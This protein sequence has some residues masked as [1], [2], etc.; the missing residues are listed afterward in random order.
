MTLGRAKQSI[1]TSPTCIEFAMRTRANATVNCVVSR[2]TVEYFA[3]RSLSNAEMILV[4]AMNR[5][6]FEQLASALYD[7]PVQ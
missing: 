1:V 7:M 2:T 4:F 3:G 5:S 6:H